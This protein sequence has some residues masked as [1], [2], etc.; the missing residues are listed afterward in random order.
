MPRVWPDYWRDLQQGAS[1]WG[2]RKSWRRGRAHRASGIIRSLQLY[3]VGVELAFAPD[4]RGT[5]VPN[6]ED[7]PLDL[8]QIDPDSG[9]LVQG[10]RPKKPG[11]HGAVTAIP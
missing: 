5:S 11:P 4:L 9:E 1:R 2:I 6:A 8:S 10:Y 3:V 7:Q